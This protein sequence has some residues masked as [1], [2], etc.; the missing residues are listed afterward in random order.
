MDTLN[1]PHPFGNFSTRFG[2]EWRLFDSMQTWHGVR[3][4][5]AL[6]DAAAHQ[7]SRAEQA[8]VLQAMEAY[9]GVLAAQQQLGVA[10][11][12]DKTAAAVLERARAR[13]EQGVAVRSDL[14][15]AEVNLAQ[16]RQQLIRA[17]NELLLAQ[18]RLNLAMGQAPEEP[19]A[20][21]EMLA[22]PGIAVP[23]LAAAEA[24]ALAQRADLKRRAAEGDAQNRGVAMARSAFGPRLNAFGSWQTDTGALFGQGGNHWVGGLQLDVDLFRGG[25]RRAQLQREEALA[26]QSDAL[27]QAETDRVRLEVREAWYGLD[28]ARQQVEVA[29]AVRAQAEESYRIQQDRYEAGLAGLTDL[30]RVE[31]ELRRTQ[32]DHW[33]AVYRLRLGHAQLEFATGSLGPDSAV[34]TP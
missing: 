20:A 29:R 23:A 24:Q 6:R 8:V 26:R 2:A 27:R 10:E 7:L 28:A 19:V 12:A 31:E 34:V 21:A 25:A 18:A 16:R 4:T 3:R 15:S 32:S 1:R 9:L 13:H 11:Q 22:P 5:E 30:L 33:N 17:R 14:L